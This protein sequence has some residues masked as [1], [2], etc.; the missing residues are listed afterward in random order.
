MPTI[1]WI[2]N[3]LVPRQT[4][5]PKAGTDSA[6]CSMSFE[7]LQ[8]LPGPAHRQGLNNRDCVRRSVPSR[9]I[10]LDLD[11]VKVVRD[12]LASRYMHMHSPHTW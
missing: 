11:G 5:Q 8:D 3:V 2:P 12:N 9:S 7:N 4:R 6:K 10:S 1:S